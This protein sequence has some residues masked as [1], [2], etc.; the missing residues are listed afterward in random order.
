MELAPVH[1]RLIHAM[2]VAQVGRSLARRIDSLGE[3]DQLKERAGGIDPVVVEAAALA[4]DL[5][6]PPFGHTAETVLNELVTGEDGGFEGNAQ[7][8]RIV[9]RLAVRYFGHEDASLRGLDLTRATLAAIMKYP[10]LRGRRSASN[11]EKWGI[12]PSEEEDYRW[13]R[14][15]KGRVLDHPSLEAAIMDWSDD[16][17]F[18]VHDIE[19]F[20]RAGLI[21]LHLLGPKTRETVRFLE[22]VEKTDK[23]PE[24]GRTLR[25]MAEH[26]LT[27]S[28]ITD[29]RPL[30]AYEGTLDD[31]A[32]L[33]NFTSFLIGRFIEGSARLRAGSAG[34][35][36]LLREPDVMDEVRTL[37]LMARFYVIESPSVIAQRYGQMTVIRDLFRCFEEAS[38][39]DKDG[40]NSRHWNIIPAYY[41]DEITALHT[42]DA[43]PEAIH[44][45]IAD[46]IC[47]FGEHQAVAMHQRLTG[48]SLG[49]ALDVHPA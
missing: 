33:R 18:A 48:R 47:S 45:S 12:Y 2:K 15:G 30:D 42:S 9:T 20:F 25:A 35:I 11:N 43:P 46:L 13:A 32:V 21:P 16:I 8:F 24:K 17:T 38:K 39:R 10:R 3:N 49:S 28:A 34:Q 26:V 31:R 27:N 7:S 23:T 6:H 1:N 41:R 37:K 5:G 14:L 44:R 22:W 4:H 36:E 19:D 29:I 40:K